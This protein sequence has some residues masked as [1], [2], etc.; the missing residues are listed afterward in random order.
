MR[1]RTYGIL[2]LNRTVVLLAL[3]LGCGGAS[4][5][6]ANLAARIIRSGDASYANRETLAELDNAIQWYLSGV[7]E[8]PT[9]P[10]PLGRLARAYTVRAY[11]HPDDGLEGFVTARE[12]GLKCLMMEDAF[13]GLVA[14][15]GGNVTVRAVD[16]LDSSRIGC[17]TWTSIAWA[18]WLD[19]RGV[20]GASID[21]DAV[22]AL[23]RRAVAVQPAYDGGRPYAALGL[24]LALPPEP[25]KPDL[26]G[27]RKAF[28]SA[29]RI[30]PDRLTPIVDLAQ[31]V[32][33]PEGKADEWN[34]LLKRVVD[35]PVGGSE[36]LENK[37]AIQRARAL[38]EAGLDKRW[39]E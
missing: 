26:V 38:L 28:G 10:R 37:A 3:V 24:A 22:Q 15:A 14:A 18:R 19:Q 2:S 7:R 17:M 32:S 39:N 23:A 12:F 30:S 21:L 13:G 25:L 36:A 33:A 34:A 8:F 27:A 1:K 4:R 9:E 6:R 31:Y 20:V 29:S 35:S 11:A 16:T 5:E